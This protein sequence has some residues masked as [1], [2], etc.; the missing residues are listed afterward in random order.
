M[1]FK[2]MWFKIISSFKVFGI[3]YQLKSFSILYSLQLHIDLS[4]IYKLCVVL[5]V[6]LI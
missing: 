1:C 3:K 2:L 6:P 5:Y 4:K